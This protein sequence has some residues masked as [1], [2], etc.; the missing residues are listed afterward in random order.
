MREG[1]QREN[2]RRLVG[3]RKDIVKASREYRE[4]AGRF[5][6]F[7]NVIKPMRIRTDYRKRVPGR[8]EKQVD[9]ESSLYGYR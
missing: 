7:K 4:K 3:M 5:F 1:Y 2:P 8:G 6:T 9:K